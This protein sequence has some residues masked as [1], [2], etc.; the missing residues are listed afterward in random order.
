MACRCRPQLRASTRLLLVR[1]RER[2]RQAVRQDHR[3][4]RAPAERMDDESAGATMTLADYSMAAFALLNGGRAVAYFPQ[5]GL[6]AS[7]RV[8][9][10]RRASLGHVIDSLRQSRALV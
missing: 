10:G 6:T 1:R 9:V 4:R 5:I 2:G 7:K 8:S 3:G